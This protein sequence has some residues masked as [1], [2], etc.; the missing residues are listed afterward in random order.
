MAD[1]ERRGLISRFFSRTANSAH[2]ASGSGT[3]R[4]PEDEVWADNATRP[5]GG[6]VAAALR[7][8]RCLIVTGYQDFLS[9][10]TILLDAVGDLNGRPPGSVRIV[11]GTNTETRRDLGGAGRPVAEEARRHF[12][13]ARGLSVVDLADLRAVLAMDATERGIIELRA[14]DPA[15]AEAELGRR[16][17]M[18]HAKLFIG[19]RTSCRE[20]RTSPSA[21]CDATSNSSTTPVPGP[22]WPRRVAR[23]RSGSGK[24]GG[25]GRSRRSRSC[26]PSSASSRPRRPSP[27]PF[28]RP[29]VSRL[30][31]RRVRPAPVARRN[32][33]RR[34]SSMRPPGPSMS[35]ASLSSKLPPA[36]ARRISASTS[37]PSF[38]SVTDR[39]SSPGAN[40]PISNGSDRWRSSPPAY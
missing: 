2:E 14:Y 7:E 22:S 25:T 19:E 36:R 28:T 35:T 5:V 18:L 10:L 34:I 4:P 29:P 23:P 15:L 31:G 13:G 3:P 20:A 37:R 32:P 12:L 38:P 16:P 6:L 9:S 33:S 39:P 1:S 24:R 26:G 17:P 21:A 8:P 40:A 27:G 11:F 30:G